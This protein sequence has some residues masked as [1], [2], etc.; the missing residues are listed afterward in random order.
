MFALR[1]VPGWQLVQP[2]A[3][4]RHVAHEAL[5]S[6]VQSAPYLPTGQMQAVPSSVWGEA[7]AVQ[8]LAV[9]PEQVWQLA[10]HACCIEVHCRLDW[11]VQSTGCLV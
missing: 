8:L 3:V 11:R 6:L 4:P 7:H 2:S 1:N 5:Q 9:G 10:S